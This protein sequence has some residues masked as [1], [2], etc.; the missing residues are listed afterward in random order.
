[1]GRTKALQ[2]EVAVIALIL[3]VWFLICGFLIGWEIFTYRERIALSVAVLRGRVTVRDGVVK[4]QRQHVETNQETIDKER[5][6]ALE[7][8]ADELKIA[9]GFIAHTESK[10][11][12]YAEAVSDLQRN[13]S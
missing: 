11:Y 9:R 3:S 4:C 12:S 2:K 8:A 10:R 1:M 13:K 7:D 5:R 6:K